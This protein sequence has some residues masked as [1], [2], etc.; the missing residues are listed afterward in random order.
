MEKGPNFT[1]K[2]DDDA[3]NKDGKSK[4]ARKKFT[5][6]LPIAG[7]E[8][9]KQETQA[10]NKQELTGESLLDRLVNEVT[11]SEKQSAEKDENVPEN[12]PT[13]ED[14][15]VESANE[16]ESES[17]EMTEDFSETLEDQYV[18]S[19]AEDLSEGEEISLREA[20]QVSVARD[21]EIIEKALELA[22]EADEQTTEPDSYIQDEIGAVEHSNV[23]SAGTPPFEASSPPPVQMQPPQPPRPPE[24][25]YGSLPQPELPEPQP[26]LAAPE[27]ASSESIKKIAEDAAWSER[28]RGRREGVFA[29]MLL[30]G[31]IEHFRHKRREK[32]QEKLRQKERVV[33]EKRIDKLE[34]DYA[35]ARQEQV[36]ERATNQESLKTQ[37]LQEQQAQEK[38]VE[39]QELAQLRQQQEMAESLKVPDGHHIE[40]SAWHSIE[41]DEQGRAVEHGAIEYGH[42]YYAERRHESAPKIPLNEA[43]GEVALVA[44]AMHD[45]IHDDSVLPNMAQPER[46]APSDE[47]VHITPPKKRLIQKITTPP[48]TASG[49]LG[50]FIVLV[51]LVI[52]LLL[53]AR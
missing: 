26:S 17:V 51:A 30:G 31:G 18:E 23:E 38:K 19:I 27:Q 7:T 5:A 12:E 53:V 42:E 49:T 22:E 33:Q 45:E 9:P 39:T 13:N 15:V 8:K 34:S 16:T 48:S 10:E 40:Q 29:G 6:P 21:P 52:V 3:E 47:P 20:Q 44:A 41:V 25:M 46:N 50:W 4:S 11:G 32:K 14:S 1:E 28:Q 2:S 43:A 35:V 24:F 36:S 37:V